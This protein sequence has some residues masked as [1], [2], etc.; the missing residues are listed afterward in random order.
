MLDV[1]GDM[2]KVGADAKV[3]PIN[4]N[5]RRNGDAVM[6]AGV[7]LQAYGKYPLLAREWGALIAANEPMVLVSSTY[8]PQLA[9]IGMPTKWNYWDRQADLVMIV[10]AAKALPDLATLNKW[11][12]IV[13]P[14]V[15]S[16]LGRLPWFVVWSHLRHILDDRFIV[17]HTYAQ[18]PEGVQ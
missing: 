3:I 9:L 15:G 12:R 2:W 1:P 10:R 8:A 16:G 5:T 6:G 13:L 14:R 7:A 17:V 11:E 4:W 18:A